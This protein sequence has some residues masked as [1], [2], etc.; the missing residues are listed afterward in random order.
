MTF[1]LDPARLP[2]P[3]PMHLAVRQL[4]AAARLAPVVQATLVAAVAGLGVELALRSVATRALGALSRGASAAPSTVAGT[5]R[6]IVTEFVI[7]ER[8]RRFR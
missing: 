8:V 2:V 6:T 3:L 4:P 7:R 5:T 1:P